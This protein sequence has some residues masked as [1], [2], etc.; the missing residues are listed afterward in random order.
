MVN[1]LDCKSSALTG[2]GFDSLCTHQM[3][4]SAQWWATSLESWAGVKPEG[5]IPLPSSMNNSVKNSYFVSS[6]E[7]FS[8]QIRVN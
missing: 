3:E 7:K 4:G 8:V 2:R 6:K 1:Q 5:S